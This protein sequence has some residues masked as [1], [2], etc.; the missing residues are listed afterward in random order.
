[1]HPTFQIVD[2]RRDQTSHENAEEQEEIDWYIEQLILVRDFM[3]SADDL[4]EF[5]EEKHSP[6]TIVG[7][8]AEGAVISTIIGALF[9]LIT[10]AYQGLFLS[11]SL[12]LSL[13][14]V[15]FSFFYSHT[16][17]FFFFF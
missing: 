1:M 10:L 9:T 12:S 5:E 13:S 4:I 14:D 7:M 6:L 11:L 17:F 8:R 2:L 3:R 15:F 16:I